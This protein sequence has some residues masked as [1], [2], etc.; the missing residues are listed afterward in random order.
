MVLYFMTI[1]A[2]KRGKESKGIETFDFAA[3]PHALQKICISIL[4]LYPEVD[5]FFFFKGEVNYSSHRILNF[6]YLIE[7]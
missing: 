6:S 7:I 4:R 3:H 2:H 1:I 5:Y